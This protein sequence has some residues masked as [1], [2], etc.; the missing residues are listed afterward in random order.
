M[1]QYRGANFADVE[2][3]H[4]LL[5]GYA[6]AG[7]MLSRSRN[8]IYENLRDYI[9]AVDA[10]KV[11]GVGALH[12][13]WDKLAE[14]RSLAVVNEH[15]K[16]NIGREIVSRLETGGRQLGVETFFALTYQPGFFGKCGYRQVPNDSL[17]QKVWKECVYCPKY[18]Y[19]DEAAMIKHV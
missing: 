6:A 19:C 4:E 15:K 2:A 17:P 5:N 1:V 8:S 18:P 13:V 9:V 14:V 11:V 10:D 16:Q 7:L 3:L 12:M